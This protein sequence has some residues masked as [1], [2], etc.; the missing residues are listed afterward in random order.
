MSQDNET[1]FSRTIVVIL[2]INIVALI[3]LSAMVNS[4][5]ENLET[6]LAKSATDAA[7][8][9]RPAQSASAKVK[10]RDLMDD[11]GP[12]IN[13][14][15]NGISNPQLCNAGDVS[16]SPRTQVIGLEFPQHAR[17]YVVEAFAA[18]NLTDP[19]DFSVHVVNDAVGGQSFSVTHCD[20]TH[21]TRVLTREGRAGDGEKID[22]KIG[23]WE[24]GMILVV[25]GER[26][27]HHSPKL[28]LQDMQYVTTSWVQWLAD[29]PDTLVYTGKPCVLTE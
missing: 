8:R 20:V 15:V 24:K 3:W 13:F 17:A 16:L 19:E 11:F 29:H 14:E 26:Y 23:G 4:I 2:I 22:L 27:P 6:S 9:D 1:S 7:T 25:D 21:C 10:A 12:G 28:P 5:A 18:A